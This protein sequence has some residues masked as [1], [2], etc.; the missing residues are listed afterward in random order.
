MGL[1]HSVH[2]PRFEGKGL[3][4]RGREKNLPAAPAS[5]PRNVFSSQQKAPAFPTRSRS[6]RRIQPVGRAAI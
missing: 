6:L 5:R 1:G 3:R 4:G 2:M